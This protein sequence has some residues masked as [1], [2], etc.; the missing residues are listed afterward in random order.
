[1]GTSVPRL[2]LL[3][4]SAVLAAGQ[5]TDPAYA[6]LEKAFEALRARDY[7]RAVE[8][9]RQAIA[10]SPNLPSIH[11]NLAYTLQ[12]TGE[13]EAARDE[14]A[15]AMRLDQSDQHVALE[16]AYLCYDTRQR[17]TARRIFNRIANTGDVTAASAFENVDRPL[18]EG[19]ARWR[20]ALELSPDNFSA[21]EELA[22]LAEER[23]ETALAAEHYEKAWR[24]RPERRALL[25]DL[26][27]V[28]K[29]E[30]RNEEANAAL[31]A[32]SRSPEP[33]VAEEARELLPQ[34]Y[35]FVYEFEKAL[36][37]D[38]ANVELRRELAYLHLQM[39][40]LP[41]AEKEFLT[42]VDRTPE[43]LLSAAQVGFLRLNRGNSAGA[44][45]LLQ[46]ALDGGDDELAD[47][48]RAALHMPQTLRRRPDTPSSG[49]S[50]ES[51]HLAEAS[52]EKGYL[53]DAVK[54]LQIAHESDP[55]DFKVILKLGWTYNILR[56]DREAVRWFNLARRSPDQLTAT[57]ATRAYRNLQPAL[58]RLHGTVWIFPMFSTRWHDVFNYAQAKA[59]WRAPGWIVRPYASV[60]F[61]GDVR[62]RVELGPSLGPQYLSERSVILGLGLATVSWRGT[63]GWF[64]AGESLRY[65]PEPGQSG[66]VVPDYRGGVS[67]AK[68][69]GHLMAR[70]AH[71]AFAETNDDGVFVSRFSNDALL[72]SQNRTGY[73]WRASEGAGG[74][75]F[76]LYWNWNATVDAHGE[77][78]ANYV[79][80]G[81]GVRFRF[82]GFPAA[83]L[84]SVNALRGAYLVNQGNPRG[85]NFNDVRVGI[86]YAFSR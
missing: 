19:I 35:P 85:P 38:P 71:G 66:R 75:H 33:R 57:E 25:A 13:T 58:D 22:R 45:P 55:L 42:V 20:R 70:G 21:H 50:T 31:L 60:R 80:T 12:K 53:K 7:D 16:Y 24:L 26:A 76:Q 77:Y 10:L 15:E 73:T 65:R 1:M 29:L 32:A 5:A 52:L 27:R 40:D 72:Y 23:D 81:P 82:E 28:W 84:F 54:Y 63:M 36:E 9:F 59:E 17:A 34:R 56:D 43:D 37:L 11:K 41:R 64:E 46:R 6:T 14:F 79:E 61:I 83:L 39:G 62:G 4:V 44:M 74:L 2:I 30:N 49:V 78:W 67:Y 3:V 18:R 51:R 69:A 86:W 48:V 47:R 68:G 8:A